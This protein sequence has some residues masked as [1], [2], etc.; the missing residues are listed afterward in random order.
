MMS[1]SF[2]QGVFSCVALVLNGSCHPSSGST[3]FQLPELVFFNVKPAAF[4]AAGGTATLAW[5]VINAAD[6]VIDNGVGAKPAKGAVD[7]LLSRTTTF[8]MSATNSHGTQS[9]STKVAVTAPVTVRGRVLDSAGA[10][11][12]GAGV[13]ISGHDVIHSGGDGT[14]QLASVFPP[15][16]LAVADAAG[17]SSTVYQG[18]STDSPTAI[19]QMP[20]THRKVSAISLKLAGLTFPV[21][22]GPVR[23]N[24]LRLIL[25]AQE[26]GSVRFDLD[27]ATGAVQPGPTVEWDGAATISVGARVEVWSFEN[28]REPKGYYS[29]STVSLTDGEAT[30]ITANIAQVG[31]GSSFF[32]FL[33]NANSPPGYGSAELEAREYFA[34]SEI[35]VSQPGG[36]LAVGYAGRVW[37]V[38]GATAGGVAFAMGAGGE[39]TW[40]NTLGFAAGVRDSQAAPSQLFLEPA[41]SLVQPGDATAP[42]APLQFSWMDSSRSGTY[43]LQVQTAGKQLTVFTTSTSLAVPDLSS[44]GFSFGS[45]AS[46][47]WR[48]WRYA[49]NLSSPDALA[50]PAAAY[51]DIW[52]NGTSHSRSV[53]RSFQSP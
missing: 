30:V 48:V 17:T 22:S 44:L 43:R 41:V 16:D 35:F 53:Q 13:L 25:S 47:T 33:F 46:Y 37:G 45:G 3:Q 29:R 2:L 49:G 36:V 14:F 9:W 1:R 7:V 27:P 28:T 10:S 6:V 51:L 15:Y 19:L 40:S 39:V 31:A 42:S 11:V 21:P 34:S 24:L 4:S 5:S 20:A 26:F 8:K 52:S 18:L 32:D 12:S 50:V 23:S 38:P